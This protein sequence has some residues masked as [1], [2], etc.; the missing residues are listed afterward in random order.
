MKFQIDNSKVAF[1]QEMKDEEERKEREEKE[2]IE[3]FLEDQNY[4]FEK[5]SQKQKE[6]NEVIQ[7]LAHREAAYP[8][9]NIQLDMLWHDIDSGRISANTSLEENSWYSAIKLAKM[10]TPLEENWLYE[11]NTK[12]QEFEDMKQEANNFFTETYTDQN[13]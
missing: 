6:L 5:L 12:T 8:P 10:K 11:I 4:W 3:K 2:R 1:T 7:R 9:I 13:N